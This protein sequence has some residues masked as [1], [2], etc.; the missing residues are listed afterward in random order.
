MKALA[1]VKPRPGYV[2]LISADKPSIKSDEVLIGVKATAVCGS[3]VGIYDWAAP[4]RW[5]SLPLIIGH[6]YAGDIV[7][8]GEAV[9]AFHVGDRVTG[10]AALGCGA[11]LDCR[12]G[13]SN[14]CINRKNL[15]LH[16]DGAFAEYVKVPARYVQRLPDNVSYVEATPTEVIATAAHAVMERTA[17]SPGSTVAILGPGPVGLFTLQFVKLFNVKKTIITG[18]TSDQKRLKIA[19]ELGADIIINVSEEDP[20]RRIKEETGGAGADFIFEASGSP[21]AL[22]QAIRMIKRGGEIIVI[23]FS[24]KTVE[25]APVDLVRGAVALKGIYANTVETFKRVLELMGSGKIRVKP[26][27][28]HKLR[29]EEATRAFKTVKSRE[30]AKVVFKIS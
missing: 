28:T 24:S 27:I 16:L 7:E 11:C 14:I 21:I 23:G 20:I 19:E 29:L 3:D 25:I 2:K 4:F 1:K 26:L 6:E 17:I 8:V 10:L 12:M 18:L 15:G 22:Q 9:T 13:R 30:A 5:L